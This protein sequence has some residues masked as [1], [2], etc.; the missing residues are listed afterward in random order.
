MWST[1]R[2]LWL[3]TIADRLPTIDSR[4]DPVSRMA[5]RHRQLTH[6]S[7]PSNE[8]EVQT[9]QHFLSQSRHTLAIARTSHFRRQSIALICDLAPRWPRQEADHDLA[10]DPIAPADFGHSMSRRSTPIPWLGV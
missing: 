4:Y 8:A 9:A 3:H 2:R 6:S 5:Q 10:D 7:R 1:N